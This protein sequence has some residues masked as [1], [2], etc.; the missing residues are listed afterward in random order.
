MKNFDPEAEVLK[1]N[2][3]LKGLDAGCS[4]KLIGRKLYLVATLPPKPGTNLVKPRSQRIP[5]R[6]YA[7]PD[8]LRYAK[9]KAMELSSQIAI[10]SFVW[11]NWIDSLKPQNH[12]TVKEWLEVFE[13]DYFERRKRTPATTTTWLKNYREVF[14][15]LP[16]SAALTVELLSRTIRARSKPDTRSRQKCC[17]AYEILAKFAGLDVN[18]KDLKGKYRPSSVNPRNLPDDELIEEWWTR[19][20]NPRWKNV[21]ALMAVFGLRN[22]EVFLLDLSTLKEGICTVQENTKTGF[23]EVWPYHPYWFSQ[24][25][26]DRDDLVLPNLNVRRNHEYGERVSAYFRRWKIPFCPYDLRHAW[27][28]RTATDYGLEDSIAA[29]MMGHSLAIHT[30]TYHRFIKKE[31]VQKAVDR[32]LRNAGQLPASDDTKSK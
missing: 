19:L 4:V 18:F 10:Q 32:S 31:Q 17:N 21:Y 5:L 9:A 27:A 1:L 25:Q 24:F 11:E 28:G 7:N 2:T 6:V 26:L 14:K 22:H 3:Q 23:H 29:R 13:E 20:S 8:G 15:W 12:K 16:S 30:Q